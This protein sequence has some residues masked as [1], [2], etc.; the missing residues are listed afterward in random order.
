VCG[1]LV[2]VHAADG[3]VGGFQGKGRMSTKEPALFGDMLRRYRTASQ[4]TQKQLSVRSG[5]SQGA[6]AAL[7]RGALHEQ[8]PSSVSPMRLASQAPSAPTSG[9][10]LGR[11]ALSRSQARQPFRHLPDALLRLGKRASSGFQFSQRL[12]WIAPMR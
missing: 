1:D 11:S 5:V 6:I 8:L 9:R 2:A 4:L 7:E 3:I 12:W 10:L